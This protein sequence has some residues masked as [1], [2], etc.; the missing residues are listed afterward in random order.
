MPKYMAFVLSVSSLSALA[1]PVK[2][3]SANYISGILL[4]NAWY[5]FEHVPK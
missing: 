1:V 3:H 5:A 4:I 2:T